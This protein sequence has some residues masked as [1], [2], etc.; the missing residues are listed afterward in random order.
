MSKHSQREVERLL[1]P[2]RKLIAALQRSEAIG[3][4]QGGRN[5][6]VQG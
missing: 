3:A 6:V 1:S 2:A 4:K 5:R